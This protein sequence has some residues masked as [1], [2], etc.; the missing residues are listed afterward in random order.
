MH[1]RLFIKLLAKL[2]GERVGALSK[3]L[4]SS[5][6]FVYTR[7]LCSTFC[8]RSILSLFFIFP[9]FSHSIQINQSVSPV[10]VSDKGE[11]IYNDNV[12]SYEPWHS[13]QLIGKVRVIQHI[14]ART[15]G[16]KM[17]APLIEAIKNARL[18]REHY[19]TTTIIN[20]DEAIW[21]TAV[22]V[23][24]SIEDSKREFP[25]SQFIVD[26]KGKVRQAWDLSHQ[27]SAIVLLDKQGIV[28]FFKDGALTS[29]EVQQV[30]R[31]LHQLTE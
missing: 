2:Y 9:C 6:D 17:N 28:Q 16:R 31:M 5:C 18:P 21:G 24:N 10:I 30:I 8:R 22:F 1:N 27:G 19:Q 26:D 23:R 7:L 14:A 12:F 13:A 4:E 3:V 11:L 15:D 20:L 25:W 29:Q